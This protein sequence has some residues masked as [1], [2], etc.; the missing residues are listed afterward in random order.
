MFEGNPLWSLQPVQLTQEPDSIIHSS[1]QHYIHNYFVL[2]SLVYN[3][4]M[5]YMI[6]YCVQLYLH[7]YAEDCIFL[8]VGM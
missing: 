6:L 8:A 2:V 7:V 4:C 3:T 5:L 1:L